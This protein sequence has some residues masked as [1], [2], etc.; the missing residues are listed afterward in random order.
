MCRPSLDFVCGN[1]VPKLKVIWDKRQHEK[2]LYLAKIL[3]FGVDNTLKFQTR[4]LT[5]NSLILAI[6]VSAVYGILSSSARLLFQLCGVCDFMFVCMF[7]FSTVLT[8][9]ICACGYAVYAILLFS[10]RCFFLFFQLGLTKFALA[11]KAL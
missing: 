7:T 1:S 11:G 9:K 4:I 3:H 8:N 10:T 2:R 5:L 6:S